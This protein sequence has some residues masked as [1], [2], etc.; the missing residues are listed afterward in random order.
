MSTRRKSISIPDV[1]LKSVK[2]KIKLNFW[3]EFDDTIWM[4]HKKAQLS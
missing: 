4:K 2:N 3:G 1:P